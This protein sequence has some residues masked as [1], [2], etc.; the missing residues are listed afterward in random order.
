MYEC[1]KQP[2]GRQADELLDADVADDNLVAVQFV[3]ENAV[4][5]DPVAAQAPT[6]VRDEDI[7][8]DP[9]PLC[10]VP[11]IGDAAVEDFLPEPGGGIGYN[12]GGHWVSPQ[13]HHRQQPASNCR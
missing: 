11:G 1:G 6:K 5:R 3:G 7:G 12:A 8:Q 10:H 2:L 9:L 4:F 13:P